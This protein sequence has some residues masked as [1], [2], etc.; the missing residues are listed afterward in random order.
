MELFVSGKVRH[1]A[2]T[3]M[4]KIRGGE[5]NKA[6]KMKCQPFVIGSPNLWRNQI[7]QG[8]NSR[9]NR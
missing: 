3:A 9:L 2:Q 4:Q 1:I 8:L 6:E 5:K 7:I